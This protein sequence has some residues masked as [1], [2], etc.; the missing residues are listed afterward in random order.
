MEFLQTLGI[1]DKNYGASTGREWMKTT[2]QGE[3]EVFSPVYGKRIAAV[4]R[5][6]QADYHAVVKTALAAFA[7]WRNTKTPNIACPGGRRLIAVF[8]HFS[9]FRFFLLPNIVHT[10]SRSQ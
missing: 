10:P 1:R 9:V 4:H 5:C 2:D 6:S 3:L 7:V 8:K